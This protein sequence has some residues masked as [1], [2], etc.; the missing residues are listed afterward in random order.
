MVD[1]V[2]GI[3]RLVLDSGADSWMDNASALMC[4]K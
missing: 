3:T 1:D 4:H 2:A